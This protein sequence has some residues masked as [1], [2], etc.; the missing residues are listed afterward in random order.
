MNHDET[1]FPICLQ[2]SQSAPVEA[3]PSDLWRKYAATKKPSL[4]L[5]DQTTEPRRQARPVGL[6]DA[7][8]LE[9]VSDAV[10]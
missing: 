5:E 6:F 4:K 7:G 8:S 3:E 9:A 2:G 1:P 10:P